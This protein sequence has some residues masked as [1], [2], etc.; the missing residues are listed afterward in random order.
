MRTF[1]EERTLAL[2]HAH[3]SPGWGDRA[4]AAEPAFPV[5][6]SPSWR[7]VDGAPWRVT[8]RAG[9]G[10]LFVKLMHPE[11]A[12]YIDLPSSFEA[13]RRASDLG[14][15][16]KVLATDLAAGVLVMEDLDA[17]W[18]V[19][20]LDRLADPAVLDAVMA[21]RRRFQEGPALP[22]A[23]G[24][25]AEIERFH[26]AAVAAEAQLPSD[27]DWLVEELRFAGRALDGVAI[28]RVPIH[29]DGNVS[30]VMISD[31][32]EVRL[33]DWD[34]ATT[35]DPLEDWGSVLVE[36]FEQEPEA[37][38]AFARGFGGFD[39]ASFNRARV[40]GTA[41]DLR[42][43]LIGALVAARSPRT[44]H[45]FHKFASWRFTRCRMALRAPR[46]GEML[47]RMA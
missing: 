33:V 36:A 20:T 15:G 4:L 1:D 45:E 22:G 40:Y 44:V 19:G 29:G 8:D 12:L 21:A 17:G 10:S 39:E 25:F 37:R 27:A 11:A 18:R 2:A 42:W 41:D 13:A 23:S 28:H 24:V 43:G 3:A 34:R 6:A 47:R 31:A 7:G 9:R 16:P 38:E 35:A 26:A 32:G 46:F 30:N 5:L 14:I